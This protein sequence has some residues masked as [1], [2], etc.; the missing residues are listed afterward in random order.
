[1]IVMADLLEKLFVIV[2]VLIFLCILSKVIILKAGKSIRVN[3][4]SFF[5]FSKIQIVN[6]SYHFSKRKRILMN[7]LTKVLLILISI[8]LG[9]VTAYVWLN[10]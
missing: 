9:I 6:S 7:Q 5:W 10:T 4:F 8:E 1:M 2:A 3:L